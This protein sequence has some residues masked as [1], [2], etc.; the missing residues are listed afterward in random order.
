VAAS[1]HADTPGT[2][3]NSHTRI[4]YPIHHSRGREPTLAAGPL[5]HVLSE[6]TPGLTLPSSDASGMTC[7]F[8]S[9]VSQVRPLRSCGT[10]GKRDE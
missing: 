7:G 5:T 1:V 2:G 10:Q 9:N 3:R 8:T 6:K 4:S